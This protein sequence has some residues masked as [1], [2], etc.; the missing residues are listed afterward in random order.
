MDLGYSCQ[1]YTWTNKRYRNHSQLIFERLDRGVANVH[2]INKF[3]NCV[4]MQLPRIKFDHCPLLLDLNVHTSPQ[5]P[6]PF[7]IEPMWCSHPTFSDLIR[8]SFTESH[9]LLTS[10]T[11]FQLEAKIWNRDVL[12]NIFK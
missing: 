10:I 6:K 11:N 3:P 7:C 9:N 1:R 12:G 2:W 8:N 4:D 5:I